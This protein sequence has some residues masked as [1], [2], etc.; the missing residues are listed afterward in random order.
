VQTCFVLMA[1]RNM[2]YYVPI[3]SILAAFWVGMFVVTPFRKQADEA[4]FA[5]YGFGKSMWL[6]RFRAFSNTY[7]VLHH[8][9]RASYPQCMRP[10]VPK[11]F[12][13]Y[14]SSNLGSSPAMRLGG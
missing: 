1:V 8:V 5:A 13:K 9:C 2:S 11:P 4:I 7:T 6:V 12:A 14:Q 3:W 10:N